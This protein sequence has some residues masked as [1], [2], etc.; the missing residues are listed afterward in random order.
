ML[1]HDE[2]RN[3]ERLFRYNGQVQ[4]LI[5]GYRYAYDIYAPKTLAQT[6]TEILRAGPSGVPSGAAPE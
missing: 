5:D 4:E 1:T 3:L 6:E 2:L